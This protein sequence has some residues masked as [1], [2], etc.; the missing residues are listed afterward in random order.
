LFGHHD[1]LLRSADGGRAWEPLAF[2][3]DAMGVSAAPDGSI[4]VAGHLVF[5]ASDDGGATW[6]IEHFVGD[7]TTTLNAVSFFDQSKGIAVGENGSILLS[8]DAGS[9]WRVISSEVSDGLL[10]VACLND[11]TAIAVG[12]SGTVLK[13]TNSGET[14]VPRN[15]GVQSALWAVDFVGDTL[16]I[17]VG[18]RGVILRTE[19]GGKT[20]SK[21][22]SG[23]QV[24]LTGVAFHD[25]DHA[26]TVGAS[27]TVLVTG[28]TAISPSWICSFSRLQKGLS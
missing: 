15:S 17:A 22:E 23:T 2:G 20:W 5:Q 6:D 24:T 12:D 18:A 19:N 25:N 16:G 10:D 11:S 13:S 9:T 28:D 7:R 27:G 3:E 1:G 26:T 14:W 8:D 4:I 21:L